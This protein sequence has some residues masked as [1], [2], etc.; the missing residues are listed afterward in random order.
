MR[1]R[2]KNKRERERR[3]ERRVTFGCGGDGDVLCKQKT[4]KWKKEDNQAH[5]EGK[6]SNPQDTHT[7]IRTFIQAYTHTLKYTVGCR[8]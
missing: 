1:E 8:A 3:R 4:Q 6:E 2:E 7:H 5:T